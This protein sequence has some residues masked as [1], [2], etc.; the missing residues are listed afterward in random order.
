MDS[1]VGI[2]ALLSIPGV[3]NKT[4]N[5]IVSALG[6][7][8]VAD[9]TA[10][11][12]AIRDVA[13]TSSRIRYAGMDSLNQ[14]L[15]T[16]EQHRGILAAR[17][18]YALTQ[19]SA[20]YPGALT[21][22][23]DAPQILYAQGN[24]KLLHANPALALVGTRKPTDFA[25]RALHRL[26]YRVAAQGVTVISG[27]ASGSD[28]AAH[29]GCLEA[30][31]HTIAVLGSALDCITSPDK[32]KMADTI[33]KADGLLISEYPLGT[34][35]SNFQLI[36]RNW[37][38]AHLAGGLICGQ[39]SETG[40]SSHAVKAVAKKRAPLAVLAPRDDGDYSGNKIWIR[41]HNAWALAS[42][43]DFEA[44]L[45]KVLEIFPKADR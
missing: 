37:I 29:R 36:R 3:G 18:V 2:K 15:L 24:V 9:E 8:N 30:G 7:M 25:A 21:G 38:I 12:Q 44:F 23:P 35:T 27:M 26:A 5:R 42:R 11:D 19:E 16:A 32:Q 45:N 40:G 43:E 31:G 34:Q 28:A 20:D 10:L 22:L 4:V 39:A 41:D 17:G 6:S 33:L 13:I 14:A 1:F